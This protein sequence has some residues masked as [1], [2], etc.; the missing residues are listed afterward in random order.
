[1]L[2][3]KK[4]AANF[5]EMI[6]VRNIGEFTC[7]GDRITLHVPKF[8]S[9]WMLKWLIPGRKSTHFRIRL[10]KT[11]SLVWGLVDGK[12]DTREICLRMVELITDEAVKENL[13]LRVMEFLRQ[14]YKNRF[15]LFKPTE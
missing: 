6:P 2:F 1:M 8:K 15:I 5:L 7:E 12:K 3:K 10:D 14:L 11:G 13:D 4:Q 9:S